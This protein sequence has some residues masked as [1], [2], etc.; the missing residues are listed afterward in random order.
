MKKKEIKV[1]IFQSDCENP[2]TECGYN[3]LE[4]IYS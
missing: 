1:E 4:I 2:I 3:H